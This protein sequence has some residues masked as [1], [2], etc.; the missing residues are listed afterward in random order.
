MAL[1]SGEVSAPD[2]KMCYLGVMYFNCFGRKIWK[3]YLLVENYPMGM[4]ELFQT[5]SYLCAKFHPEPFSH[6][7]VV[8]QETS[9]HPNYTEIKCGLGIIADYNINLCA[10]FHADA[11]SR[12][13]VME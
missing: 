2:L 7:G 4:G 8:E 12:S 6:S 13:G 11:F 10:N 3:D 5:I 1:V 9:V